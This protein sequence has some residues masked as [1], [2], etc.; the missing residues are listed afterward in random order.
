MSGAPDTHGHGASHGRETLPPSWVERNAKG[1]VRGVVGVCVAL[2]LGDVAFQF[3]GHRHAHFPF[4]EYIGVYAAIG[5]ASY[6]GLVMSAKVL[7][8]LV[9]R[10][11]DYYERAPEPEP[12]PEAQTD[13][14]PVGD[15][16]A[17]PEEPTS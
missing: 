7:R 12:E 6:V 10:P 17:E 9:M 13:A 1:I 11:E 5:F 14:E 4:E 2:L 16:D 8:K 3:L 15:A